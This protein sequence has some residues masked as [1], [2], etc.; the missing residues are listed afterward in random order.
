MHSVSRRKQSQFG[1]EVLSFKFETPSVRQEGLDVESA[2][3]KLDTSPEPAPGV[4]TNR[5]CAQNK[6]NFKADK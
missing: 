4:T 5:G 2:G 1:R 6:A 3:F